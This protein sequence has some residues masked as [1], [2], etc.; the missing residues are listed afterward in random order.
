MASPDNFNKDD[1]R[2]RKEQRKLEKHRAKIEKRGETLPEKE[3]TIL[4]VKFGTKYGMPYVERLRNMVERNIT[5]PYEFVCL[6]DERKPI[7]GVRSIVQRHAGYHKGWWH[8]VHMFDPALDISGRVLYFDL[9]VIVFNNIDKL[10][11][12]KTDHFVGTR[13]FNRKFYP[14]WNRL[15]SSVMSWN[16]GS[17]S[18]I[19]NDFIDNPTKA[20]RMHGDQDWIFKQAKDKL[21]F[22]PDSWVQSY[23]WEIR[24]KQE[25]IVQGGK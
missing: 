6:T 7:K 14:T 20:L 4:C 12:Y 9:D 8:K 25:L 21:K 1:R 5:I 24:S 3:I 22:F 16:H 10:A 18:Y 13:D 17:E 11:Q 2:R 19:Y 23:K 15:N